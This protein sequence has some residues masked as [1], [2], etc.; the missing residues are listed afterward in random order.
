MVHVERNERLHLGPFDALDVDV[1]EERPGERL[2]GAVLNGGGLRSD[3]AVAVVDGDDLEAV[4][5]LLVV[6]VPEI[7]EGAAVPGDALYEDVIVGGGGV[8]GAGDLCLT[9]DLLGEVVEGAGVGVGAVE[10]EALVGEACAHILP[11]VDG[12]AGLP[13]LVE[14]SDSETIDEVVVG[15]NHDGEAVGA[16]AHLNE[17][18]AVGSGSLSLGVL[19]GPGGIGDVGLA[20]G[21]ALEAT[22]GA[23]D[24]DVDLYARLFLAELL[25]NR[26]SDGEDG[27]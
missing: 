7:A 18:D 24:G 1:D 9:V 15:V 25:G 8:V 21:E 13:Y 10:A 16:D 4:L 27:R 22:A 19:D 26:L 17:L 20:D 5:V 12:G 23:G 14:L 2:V 11:V 3:A 6:G